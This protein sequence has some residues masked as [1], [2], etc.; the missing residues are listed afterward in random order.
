ML[1]KMNKM[2]QLFTLRMLISR[3][4]PTFINIRDT[5][6]HLTLSFKNRIYN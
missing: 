4:H 3:Y 2:S 5:H 6:S 1:M